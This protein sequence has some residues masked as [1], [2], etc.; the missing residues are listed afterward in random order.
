M[1]DAKVPDRS[2]KIGDKNQIVNSPIVTG[3]GNTVTVG[4]PMRSLSDRELAGLSDVLVP[5]PGQPVHLLTGFFD[6]EGQHFAKQF[7]DAFKSAKWNV[8][9]FMFQADLPKGTE[10]GLWMGTKD[11]NN[12]PPAALALGRYLL[13]T[14]H[15]SVQGIEFTDAE[16]GHVYLIVGLKP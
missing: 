12:Q 3:D 9:E 1:A 10:I 4:S 7:N 14:L 6:A 15:L 5:F 8:V 16:A 13:G 11:K 2:V